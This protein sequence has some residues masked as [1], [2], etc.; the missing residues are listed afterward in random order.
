MNNAVTAYS[1]NDEPAYL[2]L[3]FVCGRT[4]F[5]V[6]SHQQPQNA[7][8]TSQRRLFY[9]RAHSAIHG[10]NCDECLYIFQKNLNYFLDVID[11]LIK[12]PYI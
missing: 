9:G 11:F 8:K 4:T 7:K 6:S 5:V 1:F 2:R 10:L 3:P 12:A